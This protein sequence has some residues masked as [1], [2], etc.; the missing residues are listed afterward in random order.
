M[1]G[2][3]EVTTYDLEGSDIVK[4]RCGK[5]RVERIVPPAGE[6]YAF[7]RDQWDHEVE[8]YVSPKGKSVRVYVDGVE[9]RR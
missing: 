8:V 6:R 1:S 7:N 3:V 5:K 4:V 9:V 2:H